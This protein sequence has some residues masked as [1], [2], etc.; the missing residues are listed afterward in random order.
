MG[1]YSG[2]VKGAVADIL[3]QRLIPES[4]WFLYSIG[5]QKANIKLKKIVFRSRRHIT[6]I[7]IS[8]HHKGKAF[9]SA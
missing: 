6:K 5:Y 1:A 3:P 7:F 8:Q 4:Y 9:R 2:G